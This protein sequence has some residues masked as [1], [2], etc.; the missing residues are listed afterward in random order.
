MKII[1]RYQCE[2]CFQI[3]AS[4]VE[5]E[6]CEKEPITKDTGVKVGD[7]VKII[8]GDGAGELATVTRRIIVSRDWAEY[9]WRRYWH[10][11]ALEVDVDSGGCRF[12]TFDAYCLA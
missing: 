11:L 6:C 9:Q 1:Y 2:V 8:T 3:F 12:L 7:R 10:T 4:K 5:C